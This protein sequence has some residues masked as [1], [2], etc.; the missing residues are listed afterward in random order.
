MVRLLLP[1]L[2]ILGWLAKSYLDVYYQVY[3][4]T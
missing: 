3:R 4:S 1:S 2:L